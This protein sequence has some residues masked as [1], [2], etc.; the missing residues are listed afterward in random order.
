MYVRK[1]LQNSTK[2]DLRENGCEDGRCGNGSGW[3]ASFS[4]SGIELFGF[5]TRNFNA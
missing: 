2:M 1:I 3:C 5:D 4:V